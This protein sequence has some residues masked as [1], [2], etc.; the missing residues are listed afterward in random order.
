MDLPACYYGKLDKRNPV[1][2]ALRRDM[3]PFFT[4]MKQAASSAD[5]NSCLAKGMKVLL[6]VRKKYNHRLPEKFYQEQVLQIADFLFGLKLYQLARWQGYCLQLSHY[7]SVKINDIKDAAHFMACFF[8]QGFHTDQDVVTMKVRAMLGCVLCVFEEEKKHKNLSRRGLDKLLRVLNFIRIMMQAFQQHD[9]LCWQ[10]HNGSLLIYTICR[11][12]MTFRCSAQALEYLL[13]ASISLELSVPLMT[14]KYLPSIVTLYCAVCHCYYDNQAEAQAEE[15]AR[16]AL[17]KINEMA[18]L[19]EQSEVPATRETQRAFREASIKLT[20][21]MFKRVV[22]ETRRRHKHAI[23]GKFK[24]AL[25]DIP[26]GLWPHTPTEHML[27]GLFDCSSGHFLGILE[28]LWHSNTRPL[29]MRMPNDTE[30]QEVVLELLSAGMRILSGVTG[31]GEHRC[32]SPTVLTPAST[33]IDLAIKGEE[34]IPILSAVRFI[35]LLFQYKQ[36]DTFSELT[37]EML[38][39][40]SV[41]SSALILQKGGNILNELE[42][43]SFCASVCQGVEGQPFRRAERELALLH[44]FNNLLFSQRSRPREDGVKDADNNRHKCFFSMSDALTSLVDTLHMSVCGCAPELQPDGDLVLDT[45]LFLWNKVKV[46]MKDQLQ[47]PEFAHSVQSMDYYDKWLWCLSVLCEA[48][49][50]SELATSDCI[51]TAEMIYTLGVQLERASEHFNQT[52]EPDCEADG[53]DVKL[54]S[55]YILGKSS[56]ELLKKV[57]EVVKMGLEALA[58]AASSLHPQDCSAVTD[59][60]FM[61]ASS[62]TKEGKETDCQHAPSTSVFLLAKDLHLELDILHHRASLK[63]LQLNAV[64]ESELLDRIKKNKLSKALFLTQRALL[65]HNRVL[66]NSSGKAQSLLQEALTLIEK[67][68]K[69]ERKVHVA[70]AKRRGEATKGEG[71]NPP[72]P[73]IL[74]SRTD[75]CL[76]FA[77]APYDM[78]EQVCWYQLCGRVAEGFDRKVRLGDCSLP[79]TGNMV[80][81]GSG[82]C[83]LTAEALQ[84]NQKYVFAAAAYNSQGKLLGNAIGGT[85][86]PLLASMPVAL[87]AS[88]AHLAQVAFQTEQYVIA[89]KACR[90]LWSHFTAPD[91][92][93]SG[94]G[95][96]ATGLHKPTLQHSSPH[97][98][99]LLLT[100]IFIET[101]IN[102]QQ[103]SLYC[104]SFSDVG[105]FIWEEEARLAEC[106]RLLVAMD[107]AMFLNDGRAAVQAVVTCYGLLAPLIFHQIAH[108][109]VVQVLKKCLVV[110]EE[111]SDL[112][113]DGWTGNTLESLVHMIAC[114][115]FYLSK[116]FRELRKHQMAAGVMDCGRRLLQEVYDAQLHNNKLPHQTQGCKT[117]AHAAVHD[118]TGLQLKALHGTNKE[119]VTSEAAPSTDN[120]MLQ[121]LTG[122]EDPTLLY[123]LICSSP[124]Q[125]AYYNVMKIRRK[126]VFLEF[127]ALLLQ[128]TMEEGQL[129]LVLTWGQSMFQFLSRRDEALGLSTKCVEANSKSKKK[130][131]SQAPKA[132]ETP[133]QSKNTPP[134]ED[135]RKTLKQKAPPSMSVRTSRL[136]RGLENLLNL[137]SSVVQRYK[138]HLQL[139][140]ICSEE[141]V[142]RCRLNH[143]MARA[144]LALLYRGLDQLHG[145]RLQHR[146]SQCNPLNFSLACSGVLLRR[147]SQQ[148]HSAEADSVSERAS[149]H[150]ALRGHSMTPNKER[151]K[152]EAV[153]EKNWTEGESSSQTVEQQMEAQRCTAASLLELLNK[154]AL[155]VQRAMVLAHRGGHWTTLQCV[156]RGLWDQT[157]RITLVL[158]RAAQLE[159]LSLVTA[160]QLHAIFTPLLVL[161]SDLIM[162]MLNKL[163]LW[164]SY[165]SDLTEDELESSLHFSAPLDDSTRVDLRWVRTLVLHTLERLHDSRKWES[166]AHFALLFN[167]YTRERYALIVV[168]LL[169]H[170]QRRLLE[171]VGSLGGAAVPQPHH[172]KTQRVTGQQITYRSYAGSQ[173]LSGWTPP[174]A[175]QQSSH[176]KAA[177]TISTPRHA[178]SLKGAEMERSKSLVCVPLD[179]EDTLSCYRQALEK[180]PHCLQVFQHSRSLLVLLLAHTQPCLVTQLHHGPARGL[181]CSASRVNFT[182]IAVPAPN[183]QPC[184]LTE[185][186]FSTPHAIYGLPI[187]SDHIATVAAAYSNSIKY[188]QANGHDSL[189]VLALHEMGNL[190]FYAGNTR[191]AHSCWSKAVDCAFQSPGVLE[192]W[193]GV[194]FVCGSVQ[195]TVNQAGVWGCLQAAVLTAKT[196]QFI[197][198][199]DISQRTR[200]CLLSASLFKSVLCCSVAQP[201]AD[202]QYASHSV[203]HELLP[204]VDLFSETHRLHLGTTVASLNFICN[205]LFAAGYYLTLLPVLALYLHFAGHVCRDVQRTVEG[206]ILKIRALTQLCLFTEALM[207]AVHL[208]LGAGLFL[209]QGPY[210]PKTN[211]HPVKRFYSNKPLLDNMEAL[212]ELVNCDF[213]PEVGTLYGP[214]LCARFNLARIQLVLALSNSVRGCPLPDPEEAFGNTTSC[215]V[216]SERP[217][218]DGLDTDDSCQKTEEEPRCFTLYSKE[219][220]LTPERIKFLLLEGATSL[221]CSVKQQ[222]ASHS[223][224]EAESLELTVESNLLEANLHLQQRRAALSSEIAAS[225][226]ELLQASPIILRES[227]PE[228]KW[229]TEDCSVPNSLHGDDP[230]AVEAGERI[231]VSLWLRCRSA[232]IH[233]LAANTSDAVA[234]FPGMSTNKDL[235]RLLKEGLDEC[236]R[237]GDR[238]NQAL[239][240]V[241]EAELEV[242]RGKTDDSIATLQEAVR[243]LSGRTR[244][245]PGCIVAL[246]RATLMLSDLRGVKG[247]GLLQLTQKLLL[248]QL[249]V[250]GQSVMMVDGNISFSPPGPS[251][252]YLPYLDILNEVTLQIGFISNP[253]NMERPLSVQSSQS[254]LRKSP[255]PTETDSQALSSPS[256]PNTSSPQ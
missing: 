102:I 163:Q 80:P 47:S 24:Y 146:Y 56:T 135:A 25:K 233:S 138:K 11:H 180:R 185:E 103:G 160:D 22:F 256:N 10:I 79:G 158:Q 142:W 92:E 209:P 70:P 8:P 239:L 210:I 98:C 33:L 232:L 171:R 200:C 166:L 126:P 106:E 170:A 55:F 159:E 241:E 124:L 17:G 21:L 226:L 116:A 49:L 148:L 71:E 112:L 6:E 73:P 177:R 81:V 14:A 1:I 203:G 86:S 252:I 115:T 5:Q 50:A 59:S 105:P 94:D 37:K 46:V 128:R 95:I 19:E 140:S 176:R 221:L 162:D 237:W 254:T 182:P 214:T 51:M 133:Q 223:C 9:H 164:S 218:P 211:L 161:A 42:C 69:E 143:C 107:L 192:K 199:S 44:S 215:L 18:K 151:K 100:S 194:S 40:L 228:S 137:M 231:G 26:N 157:C 114:I 149:S 68:C 2:S 156:C 145:G 66:Q 127:A 178:V 206:K 85:T 219:E 236:E 91:S 99:Q 30:L 76:T 144:H 247:I 12:L 165:D 15:F 250:F 28:A 227:K 134:H 207:E 153:S 52:Q 117:V 64:A 32:F 216:D 43:E 136:T 123:D 201:Q 240:M 193:D 131:G 74:L 251:N 190:Q 110:L 125:D 122:N 7:S 249:A 225:S 244:M 183:V 196:A 78:E 255:N 242:R 82:E 141:S 118:H 245:P 88:W 121:P 97:L 23:R 253:S 230:R 224:N 108:D 248:K 246:A 27:T 238:D 36:P 77:P 222:L 175:Q 65:E 72:P 4:L 179:V 20:A 208:T 197:L 109:P 58:K 39:V 90:E 13:W 150:C 174:S 130:G 111:N 84:P 16:R 213:T 195:E 220:K 61:Q 35:K 31:T 186:D 87:L 67:A 129:E 154:A 188:L 187:S 217:E 60:A 172:V 63:L 38:H 29:Q 54:S 62:T 41:S 132:S 53:D 147:N 229:D 181:S 198:T 104:N 243:L 83:V 34:K 184:D 3:N 45:V 119:K 120:E 202:L 155:H 189:R 204:G 75:H 173:L 89:K 96:A 113:K 235:A 152:K 191:A 167:S 169:V 101:E 168:P 93:F 139:R 57:C 205:W 48:A 234:S 212:E